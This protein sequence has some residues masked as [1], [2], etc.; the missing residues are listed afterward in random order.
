M[1]DGNIIRSFELLHMSPS[2]SGLGH[3]PFT[4]VTGV[5]LP[6][7]TPIMISKD[8][9]M[10]NPDVVVMGLAVRNG[11]SIEIDIVT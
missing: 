10:L 1:L 4:P 6:V 11:D 7:G 9:V 3:W 8:W 2:S 5:R